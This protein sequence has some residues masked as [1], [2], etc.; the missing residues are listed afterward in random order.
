VAVFNDLL[1]AMGFD[2][3]LSDAEVRT[4]LQDAFKSFGEGE[5]AARYMVA[6]WH[7]SPNTFDRFD[8]GKAKTGSFGYGLYFTSM[9]EVGEFYQEGG[10]LYQVMLTPDESDFLDWDQPL[11]EQ[12]LEVKKALDNPEVMRAIDAY[13]DTGSYVDTGKDLYFALMRDRGGAAEAS[14]F[15]SSIGIPG[16]RYI[17]NAAIDKGKS[18]SNFVLFDDSQVN[19][20]ARY[21]REEAGPSARYARKGKRD[22]AKDTSSLF[23]EVE[24]RIRGAKGVKHASVN[25]K[26]KELLALAWTE[27]SRHFPHLDPKTQGK[28]I[29]VLRQFQEVPVWAKQAATDKLDEFIGKLSPDDRHVF[30]MNLILADMLRDLDSGLLEPHPEGGLPFG[31][32][33]RDQ[34]QK[35]FDHFSAIA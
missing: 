3:Q 33:N 28:T 5:G 16:N 7:G 19:I 18:G 4:V 27:M 22:A 2:V 1:R 30:G 12:S 25:D 14:R 32:K 20:E 9:K 24:E 8:L 15:L 13:E 21:Q 29:E 23:P 34:V 31:Y 11:Y 10:S 35:D 26:A 6:A 17:E